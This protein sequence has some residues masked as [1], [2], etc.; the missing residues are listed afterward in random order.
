MREEL[1]EKLL[2]L[3]YIIEPFSEKDQIEFLTKFLKVKEWFTE[4]EDKEKEVERSKLEVYA[5]E[6]IKKLSI[7][8]SDNVR[9]FI[10][11]PLLTQMMAQAFDEEVTTFCQSD[12]S[13]PELPFNLD[14][15]RLY[16]KFIERKYD[17]YQEEKLQ[18]SVNNMTAIEQRERDL[19]SMREDHQLLALKVLFTE[20][21]V[22]L[23]QNNIDCSFST[24]DLSRIGIV[25]VNG[26]GKP[27]FI[28]STLA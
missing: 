5:K 12:D 3:S 24:D 18:V 7:S 4:P 2:Q 26:E 10:G 22:A 25:H 17:I 28:H 19:K 15:F 1:E 16:G 14:L 8:I 21:Q 11:I 13:M 20:E 9:K 27:H 6:L 23:F